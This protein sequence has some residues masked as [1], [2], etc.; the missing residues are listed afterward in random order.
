MSVQLQR[1]ALRAEH[2]SGMS[3]LVIMSS[4]QAAAT[5]YQRIKRVLNE[6]GQAVHWMGMF[7]MSYA[8]VVWYGL[9]GWYRERDRLVL[10]IHGVI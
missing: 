1:Q 6:P 4:L 2:K 9:K 3:T 8:W 10:A 7:Y 5:S